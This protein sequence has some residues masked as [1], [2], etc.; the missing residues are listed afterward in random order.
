MKVTIFGYSET[1]PGEP[2]YQAAFETGKKLAQAGFTIVNG[3]GPGVMRASTEGAH[4]GGGQVIGATF[5]SEGM[6]F[7]E[8]QDPDNKVDELIVLRTYVERTMKLLEEGEVYVIFNGGTGTL[9][10]FAM[11]WGLARLYFGNHKPMVF[12]GA[13]W[14]E[15]IEALAKN[16]LLR[17]KEKQVYQIVNSPQEVVRA[18]KELIKIRD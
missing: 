9:S 16:M 10:E 3:A 18:V 17:E 13:F 15:V 1:K 6:T 7:F 14:Y 11:A 12:Y 2:L 4:A 5:D 8:G